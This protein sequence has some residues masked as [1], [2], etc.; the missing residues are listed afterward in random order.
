MGNAKKRFGTTV[1]AKNMLWRGLGMR[2]GQWTGK[3]VNQQAPKAGNARNK[4]LGG[5]ENAKT[6]NALG[7]RPWDR[8]GQVNQ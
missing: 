1:N 7:G 8:K 6:R 4:L 5:R 3:L 2:K